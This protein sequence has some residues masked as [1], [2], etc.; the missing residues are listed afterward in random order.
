MRGRIL[1]HGALLGLLAL[2]APWTTAPDRGDGDRPGREAVRVVR[3]HPAGM[4]TA[5]LSRRSFAPIAW[6]G[7]PVVASTGERLTVFVSEA[8]PADAVSV[9]GW[10]E[11]F[12]GLVHGSEL[13]TVVVRVTAA[14]ELEEL[15]GR[16]ALGCYAGGQLVIAGE[17]V[18]GIAPE[19][20]ARHE[21]G[22]HVAA[23]RANPPWK[24]VDWGPKR[25]AT[26]V[27]VC[28]L[29]ASG[30]LRPG[31]QGRGYRLNPGEGFAEAFR[32]LHERPLGLP[33]DWSLVDGS[34]LPD[35]RAL[36]AV[37]DDVV[38]PWR[39]P[40]ATTVRGRFTRVGA[41]RWTRRIAT[42]LDGSFTAVLRL[43]A[44]RADR[45]V[46]FSADGRTVLGRGLWV[47]KRVQRLSFDVC[48]ARSVLVRVLHEGEPGPFTLT[49]TRP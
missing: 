36:A 18:D 25:W 27:G 49:F 31:D 32:I 8:L 44:G 35:E 48:G 21:Y 42:P 3:F 10:A 11:F 5:R 2:A 30:R 46:A 16:D 28:P 47:G 39:Q 40:R 17:P 45:L 7:G 9:E 29:A 19:T 22:H 37:S 12:A 23:N 1:V 26:L 24:A 43:P 14:A 13:S 41:T 6:R 20:V 4:P 38:R 34:F 15:C 33:L